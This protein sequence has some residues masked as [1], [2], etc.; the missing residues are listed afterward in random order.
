VLLPLQQL[1]I[2]LAA[3]SSI[4]QILYLQGQGGDRLDEA[5][6]AIAAA[7][8]K[9]P[10]VA[11]A[12]APALGPATPAAPPSTG[13]APGAVPKPSQVVRAADLSPKTYL[14][15]EAEVDAY[16]TSLKARLVAV[17]QAGQGVRIQ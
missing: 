2:Q 8:P 15:T 10:L 14:E 13:A 17:L 9:P 5:M 11:A 4:P 1:K 6:D 7:M 12:P 3:Q 16:I